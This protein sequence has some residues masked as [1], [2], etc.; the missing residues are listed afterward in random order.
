MKRHRTAL[1]AAI[2][3]LKSPPADMTPERKQYQARLAAQL[4]QLVQEID[5]D[6]N[7]TYRRRRSPRQN[8][9]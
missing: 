6:S 8:P 9:N 5:N 3:Y 7:Q 2:A 4:D 1:I